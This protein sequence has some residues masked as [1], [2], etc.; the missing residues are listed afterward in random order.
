M[1]IEDP[2]TKVSFLNQNKRQL[3]W[4]RLLTKKWFFPAVYLTVVAL[5]LGGVWLIQG[6]VS[7]D[8]SKNMPSIDTILPVEKPSTAETMVLP[9][10]SNSEVTITKKFYDEKMTSKDKELALVNYQGTFYRN[11]GVN[12]SRKDG[13]SFD[14]V[15]ALG[16]TVTRVETNPVVGLQVEVKHENGL[17]TIYQSLAAASAKVGQ[18]VNQGDVIGQAGM[19]KFEQA[20]GNH[21]HFEVRKNNQ[22]QNPEPFIK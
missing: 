6:T 16:G 1:K 9:V 2:K 10:A 18:T 3:A 13:K 19:N 14:V 20:D 17:I 15:A 11:T 8:V 7:K 22:P 5:V 12:F 4:K 21:L